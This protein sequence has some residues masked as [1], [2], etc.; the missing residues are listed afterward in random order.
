MF[1]DWQYPDERV[2]T[3]QGPGGVGVEMYLGDGRWKRVEL[4][5]RDACLLAASLL[6]RAGRS[7]LSRR[8]LKALGRS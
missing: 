6:L 4:T 3:I 5:E 1:H 8:V 2:G 7:K